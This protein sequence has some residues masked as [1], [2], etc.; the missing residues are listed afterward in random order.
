M[1]RSTKKMNG[2]GSGN[3]NGKANGCKHLSPDACQGNPKCELW[4]NF[5]QEKKKSKKGH[6]QRPILLITAGTTGA[7]KSALMRNAVNEIGMHPDQFRQFLID[8]LVERDPEYQARVREILETL[9]AN[10]GLELLL[11]PTEE[12]YKQFTDAYF[13]VRGEGCGMAGQGGCN[14]VLD[15]GL[16]D[17]LANRDNIIFEFTG[18]YFPKW[19]VEKTNGDYDIVMAYT[20]VELCELFERNRT[21]ALNA[22]QEFLATG[23][24]APRLPNVSRGGPYRGSVENLKNVFFQIIENDCLNQRGEINLDFCSQFNLDRI[25]LFNNNPQQMELIANLSRNQQVPRDVL[26]GFFQQYMST[27]AIC[28][29]DELPVPVPMNE[30]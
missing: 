10:G 26:E 7:G 13:Y 11:E 1:S 28:P 18:Q 12:L 6:N 19:L 2:N 5:C 23:G 4:N 14:S 16:D 8:D 29:G 22:T 24:P 9:Q 21:R 3:G 17:A 27:P 20:L 15:A 25:L 30:Q